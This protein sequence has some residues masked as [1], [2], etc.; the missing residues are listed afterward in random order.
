MHKKKHIIESTQQKT[1]QNEQ[2]N[3]E[4]KLNEIAMQV[5]GEN[6]WIFQ[7]EVYFEA[8]ISPP[9]GLVVF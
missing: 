4:E 2:A 8:L 1:K 5:Q 9:D 6:R 3:N 7:D